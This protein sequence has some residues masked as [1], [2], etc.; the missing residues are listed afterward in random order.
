MRLPRTFIYQGVT[1]VIENG[2]ARDMLKS[3][4]ASL[5]AAT[6]PSLEVFTLSA[7]QI[8]LVK[9]LYGATELAERGLI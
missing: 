7:P 8:E 3:G 4:I 2:V 1:A 5:L 6:D 9:A